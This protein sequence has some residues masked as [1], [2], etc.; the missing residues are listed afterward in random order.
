MLH[1]VA[2]LLALVITSAGFV[3]ASQAR[4]RNASTDLQAIQHVVIIMQENRSFDSYFG[5]YPG[6]DGIPG[7]TW[8]GGG[9]VNPG[10]IPCIPDTQNTTTGC[11][12][13]FHDT[14]DVN[15]GGPHGM[16][17]GVEDID[18]GA[19][20][21][22]VQA[23]E[24]SPSCTQPDQPGCSQG[25]LDVMG[26]HDGGDI[27][28][29]W[30]WAQNFV[31]QDHMFEPVDSW[32]LPSHLYTVSNWSASCG[33][34]RASCVNEPALT[35]RATLDAANQGK[36]HYR[37]TDI[38]YLLHK[39]H[40]SWRYYIF[41]G[42][43]A[44]CVQDQLLSCSLGMQTSASPGIWNPLPEFSD[45]RQDRQRG[46][47]KSIHGLFYA[48]AN[49]RLPAVSWVIPNGVVSEHPPALVT[50]G[51]SYV[52]GVVNSIMQS[53]YWDSTAIFLTWDDW[54]GFYDH[55][56]PPAVDGNG[57]GLRVPG[58]VISPY[59]K[60]G[61]VDHQTLSFDA[62]NKFIEDD[63]L[64]GQRLDPA[65]DG[66][67]DPRPGVREA[68]PQLG[69]LANDF[70]FDQPPRSPVLLPTCPNTDLEPT[71]NISGPASI[72]PGSSGTWTATAT[73]PDPCGTISSYTWN[74]GDGTTT[75]TT[76]GSAPHSYSIAGSYTITLT[77]TD[78]YGVTGTATY[79]VSV[80]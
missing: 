36:L 77:V 41:G 4:R 3:S 13:P 57:Y 56:S 65:T 68:N 51:Q 39:A 21:G 80:S 46:N 14:S 63:F 71:A 29:Y 45:V 79:A 22:F 69:D 60:Q 52:T 72:A 8:Y 66:R 55:E 16:F 73:N 5:T 64:N 12:Q 67:P 19:M 30:A 17:N 75:S 37:W 27:P 42:P 26:Y 9:G 48:L 1:A 54:G 78:D 20:D 2:A 58:I 32:S 33:P 15:F 18:N 23:V 59:A 40:V 47:I 70:D 53:P 24:R 25:T 10:T 44:D 76:T 6:A 50:D 7:E 31:L 11:D 49:N 28:N 35:G 62:Y 43:D 34:N 38:T 74:W 61:F